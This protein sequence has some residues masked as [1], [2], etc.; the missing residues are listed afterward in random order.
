MSL[1]DR[2]KQQMQQGAGAA[3]G[4]SSSSAADHQQQVSS[5]SSSQALPAAAAA[6]SS[7]AA[8]ADASSSSSID[9]Q[10][11][12]DMFVKQLTKDRPDVAAFLTRALRSRIESLPAQAMSNAFDALGD[13][14]KGW[15]KGIKDPAKHLEIVVGRAAAHGAAAAAEADAGDSDEGWVTLGENSSSSSS[16]SSPAVKAGGYMA[17]AAAGSSSS[18]SS[19]A[20]LPNNVQAAWN[21]LEKDC[22]DVVAHMADRHRA[23]IKPL[24]TQQQLQVRPLAQQ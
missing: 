18:S 5:R 21:K 22:P 9:V 7:T 8:P 14:P 12:L 19:K 4:S 13:L 24:T 1:A 20:S 23:L 6:A 17:A 11:M 15:R 2:L 3:V 16:S 10:Q